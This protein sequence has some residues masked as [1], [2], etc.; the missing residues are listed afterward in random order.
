MATMTAIEKIQRTTKRIANG[1]DPRVKPGQPE[2]FTAAATVG[3]SIR[4]GDLY[5]TI[6]EAVPADYV[7][8]EKPKEIDKQ[9]VPGNTVG[10]KHCLDSLDGVELYRP[11]NWTEESLEGPFLRLTKERTVIHPTH[12]HV[13]IPAGFGAICDYQREQDQEEKKE[14]RARD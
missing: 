11:Q 7:R 8:I 5:V 13:T 6:W 9:L 10:A 14:R 2:R 1:K 12:G 3:D 4:Q